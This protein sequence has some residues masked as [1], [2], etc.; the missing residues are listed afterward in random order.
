M[1]WWPNRLCIRQD[2]T[3]NRLTAS[4]LGECGKSHSFLKV[5]VHHALAPTPLLAR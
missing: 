1:Q 5:A 2:F 3:V 4:K